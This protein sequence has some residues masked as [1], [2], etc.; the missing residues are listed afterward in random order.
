M[1]VREFDFLDDIES[2]R[3]ECSEELVGIRDCGNRNHTEAFHF[4]QGPLLAIRRKPAN[5]HVTA[6][7]NPNLGAACLD[8]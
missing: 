2:K 1:M 8:V 5:R 7:R 4:I 3:A 6:L